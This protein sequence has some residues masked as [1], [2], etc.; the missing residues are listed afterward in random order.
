MNDAH[1]FPN[2]GPCV[3]CKVP[4]ERVADRRASPHC[5]ERPDDVV[6]PGER[7]QQHSGNEWAGY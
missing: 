4:M 2:G 7:Q 1:Y 3:W 5:P 6:A